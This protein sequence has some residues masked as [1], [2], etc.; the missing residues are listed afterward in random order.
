MGLIGLTDID[1]ISLLI[2]DYLSFAK[3]FEKPTVFYFCSFYM[4]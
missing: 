4:S 1:E 3:V 2:P